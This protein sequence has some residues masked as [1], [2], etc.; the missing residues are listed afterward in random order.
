MVFNEEHGKKKVLIVAGPISGGV[1]KHI[2]QII[3]NIDK[4]RFEIFLIHGNLN[5]DKAFEKESKVLSTFCTETVCETLIRNISPKDDIKAFF[6]IFKTIKEIR[7]DVVH[8]HSSKAGVLGRMAAKLCG[9]KKIIYTP[10]AYSFLADEFSP[11]KRFLFKTI[12]KSLNYF[13]G[14][15]T[16]NVSEGEKKQALANKLGNKSKFKVIYNGLPE[17]EV[18]D[19]IMLRRKFGL[20][21]DAIIIGNNARLSVQKDPLMFMEVAREVVKKDNKFHFVWAGTGPLLKEVQNY[22]EDNNLMDNVHLL[23]DRADSEYIVKMYDLFFISSLYEGLPYAPIEALRMG[24]PVVGF[25]TVG[26]REIVPESLREKFLVVGR[27]IKDVVEV[28]LQ[29]EYLTR[30]CID[31][32]SNYYRGLFLEE[33]MIEKIE[34]VYLP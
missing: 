34:R 14:S 30:K 11:R 7:P 20:P 24:V 1:R 28:I 22:I 3:R 4:S 15:I 27:N 25:D 17:I 33:T 23:G 31:I 21:D 2:I 32:S 5:A 8:C 12:E 19:K 29:R 26:V 6:E 18:P 9:V 10:H 16:L 13:S